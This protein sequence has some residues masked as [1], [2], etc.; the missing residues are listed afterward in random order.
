MVAVSAASGSDQAVGAGT[1]PGRLRVVQEFVN[2]RDVETGDDELADGVAAARWLAARGVGTPRRGLAG[3]DLERLIDF[4]EDLRA[5]ALGNNGLG[6]PPSAIGRI[7]RAAR[8]ASLHVEVGQGRSS[9]KPAP[10]QSHGERA[11]AE[12]I[13][14]VHDA[15]TRGTWS[16]LKA[17]KNSECLWLFYDHSKNRSSTWCSMS[18][19]GNIMKARAYRRRRKGAKR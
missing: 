4:R 1:A 7:N 9:L 14:I 15:I 19:C 3:D 18:V 8:R 12:L 6:A 2:T 11:I 5:L 16:R 17:C 10:S 13:G